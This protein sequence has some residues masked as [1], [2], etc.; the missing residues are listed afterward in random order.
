MKCPACANEMSTMVVEDI[1]VDVCD[2][3][4]GGIWFD[5]FEL[6]KVDEPHE[7][8]GAKL[9][10]LTPDSKAAVDQN[11]KRQCPKCENVVMMRHFFSVK[12]EVQVD[13]CPSC[14]G[15][16][17]DHGELGKIRSLYASEA[18]RKAAAQ[19]Y[20]SE[21]FGVQLENMRKEGE[22]KAQKARKIAHLFRFICPSYYISGKQDWGAF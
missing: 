14:T 8:A 20:F 1:S 22:A 12:K 7:S 17:L 15:I 16:W 5:R 11:A 4:C 9:V 19:S 6:N 10:E 2:A 21:I 3:G 18:E 13:E